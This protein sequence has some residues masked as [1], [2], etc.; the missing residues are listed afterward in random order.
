[1]SVGQLILRIMLLDYLQRF[2]HR[3]GDKTACQSLAKELIAKGLFQEAETM[4]QAQPKA[5]SYLYRLQ[6][7]YD[8]EKLLV[9]R[10]LSESQDN[11]YV[12][13][14]LWHDLPFFGKLEERPPL[15]LPRDPEKTPSQEMLDGLVFVSGADSKYFQLLTEL[16]QSIKATT[17]YKDI[18]LC[19]LD[20]GLT[21]KE[22]HILLDQFHVKEIRDPGWDIQNHHI[23]VNR[24]RQRVILTSEFKAMSARPFLPRHFPGYKYYFWIDADTWLQ[25]ERSIDAFLLQCDKQGI[26]ICP[27]VI[28]LLNGK[29]LSDQI[30]QGING[31][32]FYAQEFEGINLSD[33]ISKD[34]L[35]SPLDCFTGAVGAICGTTDLYSDWG[36][37]FKK[38]VQDTIF[39]WY[40]E[41]LAMG[42][43]ICKRRSALLDK[44][45][46]LLYGK[47]FSKGMFIVDS[48]LVG[49]LPNTLHFCDS[50]PSYAGDNPFLKDAGANYNQFSRYLT[51]KK[52]IPVAWRV[53]PWRNKVDLE[54]ELL[55]TI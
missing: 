50:V 12:E 30:L 38:N 39:W 10:M 33:Y 23:W 8:E 49:L 45:H 20:C 11:Y 52:Q 55:T 32:T 1:M 41:T 19:I 40:S 22:R 26:G 53:W 5:L 6:D 37:H 29:T 47:H 43:T 35:N 14:K 2:L 54:N 34:F 7:K 13:R 17:L 28:T 42:L 21:D 27:S 4:L 15:H 16:L 46:H 48:H 24:N 31:P 51:N 3:A 25:D 44:H 9:E 18:P 36:Y